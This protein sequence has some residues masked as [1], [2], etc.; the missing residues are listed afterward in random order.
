MPERLLLS[1]EDVILSFG[2]KPLFEELTLHITEGDKICLVG[3][4]GAGKTT[5]M[6]LITEELELDGGKRF[7]YPGLRIGYLAQ[8]VDFTPTDT[9]RQFVLSGL[10]KEDQTEDKGYL[11]DMVITPLGLD[12]TAIMNTLSG[13]QLRR[14]ALA[15]SL[16]AEPDLLLLD[17]PTNHLDLG[18]IEWLEE[19][20]ARYPGALVCVSHD[21]AFLKAVSRK[22]FWIDRGI[23]RTCPKGYAYFDEWQEQIVEQEARELQN[24]QKKM[25]AEIDWTQGGV[26]GRRKRN[27]RRLRELGRL[28]EKLKADKAAYNQTMRTIELEPLP[29]S[30]ASKVVAEFRNVSKS[31][32]RFPS[33][34][35]PPHEEEGDSG[36]PSPAGGGGPGWANAEPPKRRTTPILK[37]FHLRIMRGDRIG[38]LGKNGSGKSTFLKLLVGEMEPDAGKIQRG[39]TVEISY[40]DQN[41]QELNP[42]KTLWETLAPDTAYVTLGQGEKAKQVH[43]CGYLKSFLFDPKAAR[44]KVATLSGGQ[45]NRLLLAKMLAQPGSLLILD[46]PTNDLDMDTLDMLQEIL[47]DYAGTLILVSHDRDFLDRTVTKVIAFEG[48]A[49]VEGYV[50]GYS[51]YLEAKAKKEGREVRDKG[52]LTPPLSPT[53]RGRKEK[54]SPLRGEGGDRREPGE[55]A[56]VTNPTKMTFKLKHELETL[57]KKIAAL[58]TELEQLRTTLADATLYTRDPQAFDKAFRRFGA[59]QK[60]LDTAETRWLELEEMR[61]TG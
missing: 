6:R 53:G 43:V 13:G 26:T 31:F 45:Q 16:V 35:L 59:A 25:D 19:Y 61:N 8:K 21:R 38:I 33:P 15:R 12:G 17:E 7:V 4:N 27:V 46:E 51:D 48:H 14:A 3:K 60:E 37:D 2:G 1:L 18:A 49:Q 55:G 56:N 11:A 52:P 54:P 39:K 30:Q 47:S 10:A 9:V 58:E 36:A 42:N 57:P 40:F 32:T 28:R 41:R 5:L 23:I 29:P 44:D 20:L 50:G 24:M 34:D 22:V